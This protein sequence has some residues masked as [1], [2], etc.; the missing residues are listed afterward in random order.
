[1]ISCGDNVTGLVNSDIILRS[2]HS[3]PRLFEENVT[4]GLLYGSRI[5]IDHPDEKVGKTY[6]EGYDIFFIHKDTIRLF[7]TS[8]LSMGAPMWDYWAVLVPLLRGHRCLKIT[9][10]CAFHLRHEQAWDNELNIRMMKEIIDHSGIEF[11]GIEG[12]DFNSQNHRSKMVLHQFAQYIKSY[13][14]KRSVIMY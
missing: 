8:R 7:P 14:E 13:F 10:A 5:D 11:R 1:M 6:R 12:V 9:R 2:S 4:H 3:L